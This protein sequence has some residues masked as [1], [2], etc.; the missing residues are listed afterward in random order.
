MFCFSD[1]FC[2]FKTQG[3]RSGFYCK[4]SEKCIARWNVCDGSSSFLCDFDNSD[5]NSQIVDCGK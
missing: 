2:N 1:K 4:S 3:N 5:E